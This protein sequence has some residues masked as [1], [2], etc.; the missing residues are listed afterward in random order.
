MG[1]EQLSASFVADR[2]M[3]DAPHSVNSDLSTGSQLHGF[4]ILVMAKPALSKIHYTYTRK[5]VII[6]LA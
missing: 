6:L 1:E 4:G 2:T 5:Q 3:G